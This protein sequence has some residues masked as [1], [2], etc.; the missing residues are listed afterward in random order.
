MSQFNVFAGRAVAVTLFGTFLAIIPAH[1]SFARDADR[2]AL[3]AA[4]PDKPMRRSPEP[5]KLRIRELHDKLRINA[6]QEALWESVAQIMLSN[7]EKF[8]SSIE[9][10]ATKLKDKSL[11]AIDDLK[12]FQALADQNADGIRVLIPEFEKLYASMTPEQK[13]NADRVFVEHQRHAR[14]RR[15]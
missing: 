9:E 2:A 15:P 14:P 4:R 11:S 13:E 10:R 12:S 7:G 5:E 1:E 8:H 6:D 3:V